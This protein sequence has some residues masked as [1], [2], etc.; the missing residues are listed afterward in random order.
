MILLLALRMGACKRDWAC[1]TDP[2]SET[3]APADVSFHGR[4]LQQQQPVQLLDRRRL[5]RV[6]L[7]IEF[8]GVRQRRP[9]LPILQGIQ[10]DG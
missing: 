1:N 10:L 3:T 6:C 9:D 7:D 5:Q 2:A 8:L 4:L